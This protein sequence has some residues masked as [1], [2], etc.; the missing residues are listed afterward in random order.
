MENIKD[1]LEVFDFPS[2][3]NDSDDNIYKEN[4]LSESFSS[5]VDLLKEEIKFFKNKKESKEENG[6]NKVPKVDIKVEIENLVH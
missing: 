4:S 6:N 2:S 3:K 1:I 5:R